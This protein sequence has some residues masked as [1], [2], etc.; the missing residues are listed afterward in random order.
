MTQAAR[1]ARERRVFDSSG[2]TPAAEEPTIRLSVMPCLRCTRMFEPVNDSSVY[3]QRPDCVTPAHPDER[4]LPPT[5]P[6]FRLW[7]T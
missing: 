3:C 6:E 2:A 4:D 5:P 1:R 7:E